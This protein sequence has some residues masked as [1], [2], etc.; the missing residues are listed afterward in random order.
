MAKRLAE[1]SEGGRETQW[2]ARLERFGRSAQTVTAF[3]A[4]ESVSVPSFYYW[5]SKLTGRSGAQPQRAPVAATGF[6][7]VG[8]AR[9]AAPRVGGGPVAAA[10]VE[11]QLDLGAGVLLRI[12]R[13]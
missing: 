1:L 2:R 10:G 11:L 8:P 4:S 5:R 7:E 3:C 9:L 12:R 6:I 13:I